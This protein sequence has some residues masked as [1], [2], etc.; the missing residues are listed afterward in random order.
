ME[1][2]V[3]R[4]PSVHGAR[5]QVKARVVI[6]KEENDQRFSRISSRLTS[7]LSLL[8]VFALHCDYSL[9]HS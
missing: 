6:R 7:V 2:G 5:R 9:I 4:P 1:I 3:I 8:L